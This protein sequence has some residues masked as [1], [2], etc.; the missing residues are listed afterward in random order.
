M[1]GAI[2]DSVQLTPTHDGETALVVSLRFANGGRSSVQIDAE[3]LRQVMAK[4]RVGNAL[5][6]VGQSWTVLDV[7]SPAFIGAKREERRI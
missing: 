7:L 3:G 2:I 6:L 1:A 4:A 5:E